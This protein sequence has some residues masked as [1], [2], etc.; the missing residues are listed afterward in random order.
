MN[1]V[2]ETIAIQLK[3]AQTFI[4]RGSYIAANFLRAGYPTCFDAGIRRKC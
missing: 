1:K 3:G 2:V 4:V